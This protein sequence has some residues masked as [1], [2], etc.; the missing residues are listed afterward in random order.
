MNELKF[1]TLIDISGVFAQK[2]K[3]VS[4]FVSQPQL[5]AYYTTYAKQRAL[6]ASHLT[7]ESIEYAEAFL[8]YTPYV[9]RNLALSLAPQ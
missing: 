9:G 5:P 6:Q 7:G 2:M 3:A 1:D 4:E 8:R